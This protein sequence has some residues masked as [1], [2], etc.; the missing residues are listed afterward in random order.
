VCVEGDQALL[1]DIA[2]DPDAYYLNVHNEPFPGRAP[3]GSQLG[4]SD[5]GG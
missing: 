2:A 1:D 4:R 3:C 5:G